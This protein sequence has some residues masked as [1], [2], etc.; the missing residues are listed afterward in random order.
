MNTPQPYPAHL[1]EPIRVEIAKTLM[2]HEFKKLFISLGSEHLKLIADDVNQWWTDSEKYNLASVRDFWNG[3]DGIMMGFKLKNIVPLLT[4][5]NIQWDKQELKTEVIHFASNLL[6]ETVKNLD[7]KGWSAGEVK[8]YLEQDPD[9]LK[10]V[11]EKTEISF[12]QGKERHNDPIIVVKK[13]ND[14][15]LVHDGNGRLLRA[16]IHET[17]TFSAFVGTYDK[18]KPET[19]LNH[20]IPTGLLMHIVNRGCGPEREASISLLVQLLNSSQSARYEFDDRVIEKND[21]HKKIQS[22]VKARLSG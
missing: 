3:I 2:V 4:A 20:W 12:S 11:K 10:A 6:G 21:C 19:E 18:N 13:H 5:E 9:I 7:M 8:K 1:L 16:I 22:E 17:P 14:S 15:L